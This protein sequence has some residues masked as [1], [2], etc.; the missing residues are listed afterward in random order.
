MGEKTSI[1]EYIHKFTT[2]L[3]RAGV[4]DYEAAKNYFVGGLSEFWTQKL[5]WQANLPSQTIQEWYALLRKLDKNHRFILNMKTGS[6]AG[7][8]TTKAHKDPDAMDVDDPRHLQA[9]RLSKEEREKHMRERRCFKCH[10]IGHRAENCFSKAKE[11]GSN[12]GGR[13]GNGNRPPNRSWGNCPQT[14]N[15]GNKVAQIKAL[16]K[17]LSADERKQVL[18]DMRVNPM[19][20]IR[21]LMQELPDEEKEQLAEE[22]VEETVE[23]EVQENF[24]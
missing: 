24:Q 23:E 15:G 1:D 13:S 6:A 20:R 8:Y 17:E 4:T 7:S 5:E 11:E 19:V 12:G 14:P 2:L 21:A 18:S 22:A 9:V 16:L 3:G 10:A